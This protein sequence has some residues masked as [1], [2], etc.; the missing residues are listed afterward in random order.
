MLLVAFTFETTRTWGRTRWSGVCIL[1]A[2]QVY[3][4]KCKSYLTLT[5]VSICSFFLPECPRQISVIPNLTHRSP[6]QGFQQHPRITSR[7]VDVQKV[8]C[9]GSQ[10]RWLGIPGN[11]QISYCKYALFQHKARLKH[12]QG[13]A[14][15]ST[16]QFFYKKSFLLPTNKKQMLAPKKKKLKRKLSQC[17]IPSFISAE[18]SDS[19]DHLWN[20]HPFNLIYITNR[21]SAMV[22]LQTD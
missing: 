9:G 19:E 22:T 15:E 18:Y 1:W 14:D 11:S 2:I 7:C 17:V 21:Q 20:F 6:N 12:V 13:Y 5:A 3:I 10:G 8:N 4:N 16:R